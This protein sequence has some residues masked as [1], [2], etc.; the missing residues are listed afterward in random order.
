MQLA[1]EVTTCGVLITTAFNESDKTQIACFPRSDPRIS[2]I[3][4]NITRAVER[5]RVSY[6][7][8]T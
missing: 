3:I 5:W 2:T 7:L 8:R 4:K 1:V 6:V